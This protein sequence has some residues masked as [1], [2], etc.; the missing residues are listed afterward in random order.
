MKKKHES[1]VSKDENK[2]NQFVKKKDIQ[3][4]NTW[5]HE[6]TLKTVPIS[7]VEH[8]TENRSFVLCCFGHN[9]LQTFALSPC[10]LIDTVGSQGELIILLPV[11]TSNEAG[12]NTK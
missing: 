12:P 10:E 9:S 2:I 6:C 5:C 3:T 8:T 7:S 1:R 4:Q 11:S